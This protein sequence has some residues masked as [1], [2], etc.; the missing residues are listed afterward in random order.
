MSSWPKARPRLAES[1][2]RVERG[3][4]EAGTHS[5]CRSSRRSASITVDAARPADAATRVAC[6][7]TFRK[8]DASFT[9]RGRSLAHAVV[10]F[11]SVPKPVM[12]CPSLDVAGSDLLL[13][14]LRP[15]EI[16]PAIKPSPPAF[17]PAGSRNPAP[18][19]R[20]A[21]KK[22]V[23]SGAPLKLR[24]ERVHRRCAPHHG[25]AIARGS[26]PREQR[27]KDRP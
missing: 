11:G 10:S 15:M 26:A 19:G 4:G 20:F 27:K 1:L 8:A 5:P 25:P 23:H 9:R 2:R 17:F 7:C 14:A 13:L 16:A 24:P 18:R 12:V 22:A 21:F 6:G 3:S